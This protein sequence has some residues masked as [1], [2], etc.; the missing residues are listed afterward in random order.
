MGE[1]EAF[2]KTEIWKANRERVQEGG[3]KEQ[4]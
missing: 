2:D 4:I 1:H 3:M